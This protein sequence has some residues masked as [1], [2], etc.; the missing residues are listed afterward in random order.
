MK[1]LGMS[2][3]E[4]GT[5]GTGAQSTAPGR[6]RRHGEAAGEGIGVQALSRFGVG[7]RIG[8]ALVKKRDP[9]DADVARVTVFLL[10]VRF[11]NRAE[12]EGSHG[13]RALAKT[14]HHELTV[15]FDDVATFAKRRSPAI[16]DVQSVDGK[17]D[18]QAQLASIANDDGV[19]AAL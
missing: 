6:S 11:A 18:F 7:P 8:S 19:T 2:G 15:R 10:S 3:E 13:V 16:D 14:F 17:D 1:N 5:R 9:D 12:A 4:N